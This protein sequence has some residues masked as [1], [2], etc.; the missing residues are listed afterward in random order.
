MTVWWTEDHSPCQRTIKSGGAWEIIQRGMSC[1]CVPKVLLTSS[2]RSWNHLPH[3]VSYDCAHCF[4][5]TKSGNNT[6]TEDYFQIF[7]PKEDLCWWQNQNQKTLRSR[8][9][10]QKTGRIPTRHVA[11]RLCFPWF[12][13]K[14]QLLLLMASDDH[15][16]RKSKCSLVLKGQLCVSTSTISASA[17]GKANVFV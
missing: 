1:Q 16:S 7:P 17:L 6:P 15:F 5:S 10:L 3:S 12:F 2:N 14:S 13:F 4:S 9:K 11:N 8:S